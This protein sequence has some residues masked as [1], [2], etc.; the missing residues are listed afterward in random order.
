MPPASIGGGFHLIF[1]AG[2][3]SPTETVE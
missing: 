3:K 1:S 2:V